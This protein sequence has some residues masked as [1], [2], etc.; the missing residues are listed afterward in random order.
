[1]KYRKLPGRLHQWHNHPS[2]PEWPDSGYFIENELDIP[3]EKDICP[4]CASIAKLGAKTP[5]IKK[6]T[7]KQ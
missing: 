7:D 1:M 4:N 5:E 6:K 2:C 3:Q